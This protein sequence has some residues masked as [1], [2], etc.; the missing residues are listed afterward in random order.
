MSHF[1]LRRAALYEAAWERWEP[2]TSGQ[3]LHHPQARRWAGGNPIVG[4]AEP[5]DL[6]VAMSEELREIDAAL[7]SMLTQ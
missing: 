3:V 6:S 7:S 5:C 2:I 4:S 1:A